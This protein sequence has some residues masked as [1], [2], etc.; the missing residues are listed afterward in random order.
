[1]Q[2]TFTAPPPNPSANGQAPVDTSVMKKK[3][4]DDL[5]KV[6]ITVTV[7]KGGVYVATSTQADGRT[8]K[9]TGQWTLKGHTFT[10]KPNPVKEESGSVTHPNPRVGTI[11]ANGKRMVVPIP[12]G[13]ASMGIH[14]QIVFT[15]G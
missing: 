12:A 5:K 13:L 15:K 7:K 6:K 1:M 4:E 11:A 3:I 10:M 14:G 8:L 9:T 2:A